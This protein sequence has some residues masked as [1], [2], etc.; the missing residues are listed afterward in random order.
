MNNLIKSQKMLP[1]N[2]KELTKFVLIG[3]EKLISVR[4]CIRAIIKN[5]DMPRINGE[6]TEEEQKKN[7][8]WPYLN[9]INLL[10]VLNYQYANGELI[11]VAYKVKHRDVW[12]NP[13]EKQPKTEN[14]ISIWTQTQYI[15][16]DSKGKAIEA[17]EHNW[18]FVPVIIQTGFKSESSNVIGESPFIL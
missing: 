2:I 7:R 18:G 6:E 17:Y 4:A 14:E 13:L 11:W 12:G 1:D 5:M 9:M 16:V 15:R 8:I 10:D 3:R